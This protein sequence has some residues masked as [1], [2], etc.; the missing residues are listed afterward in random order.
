MNQMRF[1][2]SQVFAVFFFLAL[3][4][5]LSAQNP[6]KVVLIEEGTGTWCQHCPRGDVYARELQENYPGQF[7][8][9]AIHEG[10]DMEDPDYWSAVGLDALPT[11]AIDRTFVSSM[12]PFGALPSDM[13]SQLA[14]D[15]PVGVSVD[16]E[17]DAA[18]REILMTLTSNFVEDMQGDLRM[19]AIVIEDGVTGPS[20]GYDQSN[21]YSGGNEGPMDGYEDLPNPIPASLMVYNHVAR[22][23]PGGYSGEPSSLSDEIEAG[24][25]HSFIYSYTLPESYREDYV[26]VIGIVLDNETGEVL[27]AG[28]SSYLPGFENGHPFFHSL[29]IESGFV[30]LNYQYDVV[31][32]DPEHHEMNIFSVFELPPGLSLE[33]LGNGLARISG[34]P[35]TTGSYEVILN[36]DDGNYEVQQTFTLVISNAQEDWIQVGS[37]GINNFDPGIVDIEISPNGKV[38]FM[39]T[40]TN[41]VAEVYQRIGENWTQ[42]DPLSVGS[43]FHTAMHL[44]PEDEPIVFS[45]GI[46]SLWNGESWEQVGEEIS[47]NDFLFVDVIADNVGR[48][49][50]VH[51]APPT[52]TVVHQYDGTAWTQLGELPDETGVW[53]RFRIG[54]D[55]SLHLLYGTDGQNIAYSKL[56]KY[57]NNEWIS[58]G[59][60]YIE[61]SSQTYFDHDVVQTSD[62]KYF[63]A[64][65]IGVGLEQINIYQLINESWILIRENLGGGATGSANMEA[66]GEGNIIVTFRDDLNG[67]RMSAL[68][69]DGQNWTYMGIP[70][71]SPIASKASMSI[72]PEG[73]PYVAYTDAEQGEAVSVERYQNFN[74]ETFV[75]NEPGQSEVLLFPNP[76]VGDLYFQNTSFE[77]FEIRDQ[78]GRLLLRGTLDG[79]DVLEYIDISGLKSG[80]HFLH[81]FSPNE[82]TFVGLLHVKN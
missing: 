68:R 51:F 6:Q 80:P 45:D 18:T 65:N 49:Y 43:A 1:V 35:E 41:G 71:F 60:G 37:P 16:V 72:D 12:D 36:L 3:T 27:N 47:S 64:L 10:D 42:L 17:W 19:A 63:A 67:S 73:N 28:K 58:I 54:N 39:A 79:R 52:S 57:D 56:A 44:T 20:P 8:F 62:G 70:G 15:P 40:N 29:P 82:S 77:N 5:L 2:S 7:V 13:A 38:F 69:Y 59:D 22:H 25:S 78:V 21:A 23:L 81:L 33:S 61:P 14:L 24:S 46:V 32:H 75:L 11:G 31:A 76:A 53:N 26:R 4:E 50:T 48:L 9:V 55:N 34:V 74:V 66:D 30:G